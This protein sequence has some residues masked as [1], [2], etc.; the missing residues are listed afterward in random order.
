MHTTAWEPKRPD[1]V[2]LDE[3][4][5]VWINDNGD[6]SGDLIISRRTGNGQTETMTIPGEALA[7]LAKQVVGDQLI[8]LLEENGFA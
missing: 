2:P 3:V 4:T 6:F 7:G 8:G 5:V 1:D